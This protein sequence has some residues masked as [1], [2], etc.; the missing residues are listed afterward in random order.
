MPL[1][2]E[3]HTLGIALVWPLSSFSDIL[4]DP[5]SKSRVILSS[6]SFFKMKL[7]LFSGYT[8]LQIFIEKA[9]DMAWWQLE[10]CRYKSNIELCS[11]TLMTVHCSEV[12]QES[13]II[14]FQCWH[15]I[16]FPIL[17]P[18]NRRSRWHFSTEFSICPYRNASLSGES[19]A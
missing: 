8:N 15:K 5:E 4:C 2:G 14:D 17:F 13:L 10:G 9:M 6:F 1:L 19:L 12:K 7:I 16:L 18:M 3:K 11:Q